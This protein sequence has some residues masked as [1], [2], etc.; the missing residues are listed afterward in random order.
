[1]TSV[2]MSD[3]KTGNFQKTGLPVFHFFLTFYDKSP[4]K[5]FNQAF[6]DLYKTDGDTL[7]K[8]TPRSN[9]LERRKK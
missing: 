1:M 4:S 3:E 7:K 8:L 2:L 6:L 9:D 5:T